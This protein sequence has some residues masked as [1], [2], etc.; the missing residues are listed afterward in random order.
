MA[1]DDK[2][3]LLTDGAVYEDD[4]TLTAIRRKVWYSDKIP[5]AI[6]GRGAAKAVELVAYAFLLTDMI[7]SVDN[8]IDGITKAL[9]KLADKAAAT[10]SE[11]AMI[12]MLVATISETRGPMLLYASN[13]N[14]YGLD[15]LEPFKL[16][17]VGREWGGGAPID[18]A[19]LDLSAG[20]RSCG[21]E[22]FE[23]MRRVSDIN[24]ARPDLPAIHGIGGHVDLT[25][26]TAS[27]IT[28]ERLRTWPDIIGEKID[29][30]RGDL[31]EAA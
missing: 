10:E 12:E 22:L 25:T 28:V 14:A 24:P 13:A 31:A 2:I 26:V 6:T 8:T 30:F 9:D 3:E 20:L 16:Y 7:G 5:M 15:W 21:V 1:H 18:P 17:D 27:G 29:P 19:G 4:G 23:R 11:P